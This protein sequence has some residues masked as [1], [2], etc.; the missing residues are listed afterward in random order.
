MCIKGSLSPCPLFVH[1]PYRRSP[2]P[3]FRSSSSFP[4]CWVK[5][6][7]S[8][9]AARAGGQRGASSHLQP[10]SASVLPGQPPAAAD[11]RLDGWT[12]GLGVPSLSLPPPCLPALASRWPEQP[13]VPVRGARPSRGHAPHSLLESTGFVSGPPWRPGPGLTLTHVYPCTST[14]SGLTAGIATAALSQNRLLPGAIFMAHNKI[15]R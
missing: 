8:V 12:W 14:R 13:C 1:W 7:P 11:R 3:K 15:Y 2:S 10:G 5:S 4:I 6:G 9:R